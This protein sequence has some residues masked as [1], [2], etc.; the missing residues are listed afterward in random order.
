MAQ[1]DKTKKYKATSSRQGWSAGTVMTIDVLAD[2]PDFGEVYY[3][4]GGKPN[5]LPGETVREK[6]S[7]MCIKSQFTEFFEEA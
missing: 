1:L 2:H 6:G 3:L 7:H 5:Y 4:F